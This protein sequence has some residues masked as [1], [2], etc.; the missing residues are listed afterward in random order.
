MEEFFLPSFLLS[1]GERRELTKQTM[2]EAVATLVRAAM[3]PKT[4]LK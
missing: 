2:V 3:S 4:H 1:Q